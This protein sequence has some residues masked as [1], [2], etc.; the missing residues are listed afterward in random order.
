MATDVAIQ[1]RD[2]K[3]TL[4]TSVA[5]TDREL[6]CA[7]TNEFVLL[8]DISW[9]E[10]VALVEE[11]I[12]EH[13][14]AMTEY[15]LAP[16]VEIRKGSN[17]EK[18][19]RT[20]KVANRNSP[21]ALCI[22]LIGPAAKTSRIR[23]VAGQHCSTLALAAALEAHGLLDAMKELSLDY[24]PAWRVIEESYETQRQV[25]ATILRRDIHT[26][27]WAVGTSGLHHLA[28]AR[29]TDLLESCGES[30]RQM[31]TNL[32]RTLNDWLN[33]PGRKGSHGK[34][35][36]T[37]GR[38]LA[39]A[40]FA[41]WLAAR[42]V[43]LF[44][45]TVVGRGQEFYPIRYRHF[46]DQWLAPALEVEK[47]KSYRNSI[48]ESF[49][50][51]QN[52]PDRPWLM[53]QTI[54]LVA[55]GAAM[56]QISAEVLELLK[57][58]APNLAREQIQVISWM[59]KIEMARL[60]ALGISSK[61]LQEQ[62]DRVLQWNGASRIRNSELWD[63]IDN[64]AAE[65]T[66]QTVYARRGFNAGPNIR[67]HVAEL[68]SVF[69]TV[70][71]RSARTIANRLSI[72]LY[73]LSDLRDEDVPPSLAD[74]QPQMLETISR[75]DG[76]QTFRK[77]M[78]G[79]KFDLSTQG[80]VLGS[81]KR[82]WKV[83]TQEKGREMALCPI[84]VQM[85][86]STENGR[87]RPRATSTTRRAIDMEVLELL[88]EENKAGEYAFSR[89]RA[90]ASGELL[91]YRHVVDPDSGKIKQVWWPGPAA[92]MDVLLQIP[93][94]HKQGRYLDSGEGDEL[95]VDIDSMSLVPNVLPIAARGRN[96]SFIK[97]VSLSPVRNERG[98]G[99]YVNTNKT[100][101]DYVFPWL[102]IE[103]AKSVQ[104]V[105]DWQRTYNPISE[106]VSDRPDTKEERAADAE[107]VL[108]YPIFRDPAR[109]DCAPVSSA[110]VLEYFRSLMRRVEAKYNTKNNT[111]LCFFRS[112]GEPVFD[113]HSLRVTG[114]TRLL[115]LGVD[116]KIV[117][118]LAGHASLVM[119]WYYEQIS[120]ERVSGAM[121][122]ALEL[123]R[124]TREVLL[125][126]SVEERERFLA[127][128]FNRGEKP[129]LALTLL[130]D[131]VD[132]RSP[133]LDVRADGICPGMK[134]AEAGVWRSKACSLCKY[135]ST[136]PAFLAGL[137]L[138]LNDLMA[139]LVL[140][141][142]QVAELRETLFKRRDEGMSTDTLAAEITTRD[143][144][145]DNLVTEWEAQ[146]QYV[147]R[148]ES[149]LDSWLRDASE[150]GQNDLPP[151][152]ALFSPSPDQIGLAL[153]ETHHLVLFTRL[154]EGAKRVEG[155]VPTVGTR[156]TRD[157][158]LLEIVRHE[159][160]ADLF[161][162]LDRQ[163][164]KIAL[165]QFALVLLEQDLSSSAIEA[166]V[167]GSRSLMEVSGA[168][169]WLHR[170]GT[171]DAKMLEQEEITQ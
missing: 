83:V 88:I 53:L 153:Q 159:R 59:W 123:R 26:M 120:N 97:V 32:T 68:R 38:P 21:E 137:E 128:Q 67:S 164:R 54:E 124:P 115:S 61:E 140:Q 155:F 149:G 33:D 98:L 79:L 49:D 86:Y 151:P 48:L 145:V 84:S 4:R 108:V 118:M 134:C 45:L 15:F 131:T 8:R 156:E 57:R 20:L 109:A 117:R 127:R 158:L 126:M 119:T 101:R 116:P 160:K 80:S 27:G 52:R 163:V 150:A 106:P 35:T 65:V 28:S 14:S 94:R 74:L 152:P 112:D 78:H 62:S 138:R 100:G 114:V 129:T 105:I 36:A 16:S 51:P 25:A 63:W 42:G 75:G 24:T 161:F 81:L 133:F 73:F 23:Q 7:T 167:D 122:Q 142:R 66:P 135:F 50:K 89:N 46:L 37:A 40:W 91:D 147:K 157:A 39:L 30:A 87:K 12:V 143:Q 29:V 104:A 22:R 76:R 111:S 102:Q 31:L 125:A 72:W 41:T 55:P 64:P 148:A 93:I 168:E 19:F 9:D 96:Q 56:G 1:L 110:I 132:E 18:A 113:I 34:E 154:I 166:L 130:R 5:G 82:A 99:M 165:D 69:P 58:G 136:G 85:L 103:I 60:R 146:F 169:E 141:Q 3:N 144:I 11:Y 13:D 92:L 47:R 10:I 95:V 170:L 171:A 71:G 77:F 70:A 139:E 90:S 162:R 43:L 17:K 107:A 6:V 121:H 2:D 44:P